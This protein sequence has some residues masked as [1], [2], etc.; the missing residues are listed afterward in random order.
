MV[1]GIDIELAQYG[2]KNIVYEQHHRLGKV[3]HKPAEGAVRVKDC[4]NIN[5]AEYHDTGRDP[6]NEIAECSPWL[7]VAVSPEPSFYQASYAAYAILEYP[8]RAEKRTIG[9]TGKKCEQKQTL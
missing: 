9:T 6:E 2:G 7:L 8:K 3:C 5:A 4:K 1:N